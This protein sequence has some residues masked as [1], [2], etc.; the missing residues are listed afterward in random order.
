MQKARQKL[1]QILRDALSA[2]ECSK[3]ETSPQTISLS[4]KLGAEKNWVP[5]SKKMYQKKKNAIAILT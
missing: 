2:V 4:T 1:Y 5:Q 3:P